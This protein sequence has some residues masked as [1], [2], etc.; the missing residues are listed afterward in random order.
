MSSKTSRWQALRQAWTGSGPRLPSRPE[1][2]PTHDVGM[3]TVVKDEGRYLDEWIRFH[4]AL[5][6]SRFF[7]YDNGSSDDTVQVLK[8]YIAAGVV[9]LI[10]WRHFDVFAN[11]Q[12]QAYAHAVANLGPSCR[13][14]GFFDVDEFVFPLCGT[15]LP[16]FLAARQHLPALGVVGLFFGTSGHETAP[17]GGVVENYTRAMSLEGQRRV[18]KLL[19]IKCFVQPGAVA[20]ARSAHYF[21]LVGT[22]IIAYSEHGAELCRRPREQPE[23]L[24][25]DLIRYN[26]YFTRSRAEFDRKRVAT[27]VRGVRVGS[28]ARLRDGLFAHIEAEAEEDH[29]IAPIAAR[30]GFPIAPREATL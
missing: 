21:D 3:A 30:I 20:A 22:E 11:T 24:T 2:R 4:S 14:V 26:H 13:W 29:A 17:S 9:M 1:G 5:G 19:N 27:D 18:P 10:P 6:V 28:Q 23:K 25:A 16:A 7:I 8:P 12:N 15:S